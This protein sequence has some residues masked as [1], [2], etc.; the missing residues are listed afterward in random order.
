LQ[1]D[2]QGTFVFYRLA[3]DPQVSSATP[4]LK[5]LRAALADPS[6]ESEMEIIRIAT[7]LSHARR[8]TIAKALLQGP[9]TTP[10]LETRL[11]I[12]RNMLNRHLRILAE[13]GFVRRDGRKLGL[14][15]A[16]HPLAQTLIR[17]LRQTASE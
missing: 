14:K 9:Q 11:R 10:D 12:R 17:L 15:P 16:T 1:V 3:P 7:A 13:G 5:A 2:R 8:I 4:L 6:A